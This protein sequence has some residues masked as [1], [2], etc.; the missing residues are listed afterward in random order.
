MTPV[1]IWGDGH[2]QNSFGK[3]QDGGKKVSS[4]FF[5]THVIFGF[6]RFPEDEEEIPPVPLSPQTLHA[7][8][9]PGPLPLR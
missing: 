6:D 8:A 9:L 4:N 5:L 7:T 1:G 3:Q 2:D